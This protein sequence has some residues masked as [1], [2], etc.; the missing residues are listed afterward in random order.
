MDSRTF[1][2]I[3]MAI[4]KVNDEFKGKVGIVV[5]HRSKAHEVSGADIKA[6]GKYVAK[7]YVAINHKVVK[8]AF[9]IQF[10]ATA[11]I[12]A[13]KALG[14]L[15]ENVEKEGYKKAYDLVEKYYKK[16][17]S[18]FT[19]DA[20]ISYNAFR[21]TPTYAVPIVLGAPT[22]KKAAKAIAD[23]VNKLGLTGLANKKVNPSEIKERVRI[24][25]AGCVDTYQII[26]SVVFLSEKEFI[27]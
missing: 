14:H 22:R 25:N 12:C 13:Y 3:M 6:K 15:R 10:G 8:T 19:G 11:Q 2:K 18:L 17:D 4:I 16:L 9:R 23:F 21:L 27:A 5:R 20:A 7:A 24:V 1:D 26:P